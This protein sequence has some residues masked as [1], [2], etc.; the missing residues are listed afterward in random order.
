MGYIEDYL[1]ITYTQ[2]VP[3]RKLPQICLYPQPT[4]QL[5]GLP[6]QNR[7]IIF[8]LLRKCIINVRLFPLTP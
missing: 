8:S 7:V 2:A 5:P 4:V 3:G 1:D 6:K